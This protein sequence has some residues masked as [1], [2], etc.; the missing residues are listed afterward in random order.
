[1]ILLLLGIVFFLALFFA[2]AFEITPEG[3]KREHEV[4]RSRSIT[5]QTGKKLNNLIIAFMALALDPNYAPAHASLGRIALEN[6]NDLTVATRHTERALELEP[7]NIEILRNAANLLAE[8][9]RLDE[10]LAISEFVVSLDPVN[11]AGHFTLGWM[12]IFRVILPE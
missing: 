6:E 7:V 9:G 2:W 10:A 3:I 4:D 8:L 1:M 11:P 5:P 12:Y